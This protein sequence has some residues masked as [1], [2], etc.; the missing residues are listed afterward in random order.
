MQARSLPASVASECCLLGKWVAVLLFGLAASVRDHEG[1]QSHRSS[2]AFGAALEHSG[3]M[4]R[5]LFSLRKNEDQKLSKKS[6]V[7]RL[8]PGVKI[9]EYL[10]EKKL[11]SS[12][13]SVIWLATVLQDVSARC[14]KEVVH[15]KSKVAMKFYSGTT[16]P[17]ILGQQEKEIQIMLTTGSPNIRRGYEAFQLPDDTWTLVMEPVTGMGMDKCLDNQFMKDDTGAF[18]LCQNYMK[19]E[20]EPQENKERWVQCKDGQWC[21]PKSPRYELNERS[22]VKIILGEIRAF[23]DLCSHGI[24]QGGIG[25]EHRLITEDG[26]IKVFDFELAKWIRPQDDEKCLT[27]QEEALKFLPMNDTA[28]KKNGGFACCSSDAKQVAEDFEGLFKNHAL[29]KDQSAKS[30]LPKQSDQLKALQAALELLKTTLPQKE[31]IKAYNKA[32]E[33]ALKLIPEN[34][35]AKVTPKVVQYYFSENGRDPA[36]WASFLKAHGRSSNADQLAREIV[37]ESTPQSKALEKAL[38]TTVQEKSRPNTVGLHKIIPELKLRPT[39]RNDKEDAVNCDNELSKAFRNQVDLSSA[40]QV[41]V[42]GIM[43][44]TLWFLHVSNGITAGVDF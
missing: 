7:E 15:N 2:V 19:K 10:L 8:E 24:S 17:V 42:A 20:Q 28:H 37:A 30:A 1:M 27:S 26:D 25:K 33:A 16:D 41:R 13:S 44:L 32:E 31:V 14:D 11:G 43:W 6:F 39:T 22:A 34:A 3:G 4:V 35:E 5:T 21:Y 9:R 38:N 40:R 23:R 36:G 18:P 12:P 29:M